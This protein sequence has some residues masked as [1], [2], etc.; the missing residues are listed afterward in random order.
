MAPMQ[1]RITPILKSKQNY[2]H[3]FVD[4]PRGSVEVDGKGEPSAKNGS[5][6]DTD[7]VICM[8]ITCKNRCM[9]KQYIAICSM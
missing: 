3:G 4:K 6:V 5:R 2:H 7:N 8:F 1:N 9:E